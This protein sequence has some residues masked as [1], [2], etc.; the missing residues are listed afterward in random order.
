MSHICLRCD[1]S[2]D[3][4]AE[5]EPVLGFWPPRF[6]HRTAEGCSNALNRPSFARLAGRT[7]Y[8]PLRDLMALDER[9]AA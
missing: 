9:E 2:I 8:D 7:G 3:E 5:E 6:Q 1:L 4:P